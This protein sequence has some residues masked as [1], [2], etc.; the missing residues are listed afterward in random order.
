MICPINLRLSL[1]MIVAGTTLCSA[2]EVA[3]A[4]ESAPLENVVPPP[5]IS[6]DEPLA[7]AFSLQRAVDYLDNAALDWQQRMRCVTCHTNGLFLA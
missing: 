4:V 6:A 1:A 7:D 5:A 2:A 3:F